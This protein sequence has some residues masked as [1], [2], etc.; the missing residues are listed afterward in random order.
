MPVSRA[1]PAL[2]RGAFALDE[3]EIGPEGACLR[4][5]GRCCTQ[6]ACTNL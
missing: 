2:Q 5:A 3:R 1:K 6:A 4:G